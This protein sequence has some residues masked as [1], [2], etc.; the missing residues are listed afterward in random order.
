MSVESRVALITGA[1]GGLGRA[2]AME[3]ANRGY[4]LALVDANGDG[5]A[6]LAASLGGE[7][8]ALAGD[9][10]E[11]AFVE[12]CAGAAEERF[13]GV[14][15]LVNNAIWREL[16]SMRTISLESWEKTLRIGLTA[17][18]FLARAVAA[19]MERRRRGVILNVSSI[20]AVRAGGISPA[21][22]AAKGGL[23]SLTYELAALYGPAGVRVLSVQ[24]GAIDTPL[25][26]DYAEASGESLDAA[27]RDWSEDEIPLRRWAKPEEIARV[28]ALLAS[29]DAAYLTGTTIAID[30]GWLH[31]HFPGE[32]QSRML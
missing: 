17:P 6:E 23:D 16:A 20:M 9:L 27:M 25:S 12:S 7:A 4:R 19:G 21:Y 3:F 14:D 31:N 1:A 11:M 13:G 22:V 8:L 10:T 15:V 28:L 2:T 32:L 26:R 29:D 30:G 24:P 5:L 18:A